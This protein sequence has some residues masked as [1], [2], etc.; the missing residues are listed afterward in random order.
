MAERTGTVVKVQK[1]EEGTKQPYK[2]E[3]KTEDDRNLKI[4]AWKRLKVGDGEYKPNPAVKVQKGDY[5]TFVGEEKEESFENDE[6]NT[7][8]YTKFFANNFTPKTQP[9]SV[10]GSSASSW[11]PSQG[12]PRSAMEITSTEVL[13]EVTNALEQAVALTTPLIDLGLK[14]V[15]QIEAAWLNFF[16]DGVQAV[17]QAHAQVMQAVTQGLQPPAEES[18]PEE[19]DEE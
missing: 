17:I 9:A 7:V 1:P 16:D 4:T 13:K 12:T 10:N 5:G 15:K 19:L 11:V 14:D 8:E 3:I 6:G 2:F 18:R